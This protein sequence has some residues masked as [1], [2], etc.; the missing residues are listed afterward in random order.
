MLAS[1]F[2]LLRHIADE[3]NFVLAT[4]ANKEKDEVKKAEAR[5]R[6]ELKHHL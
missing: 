4:T 5:T 2:E 6:K 1:N 3:I